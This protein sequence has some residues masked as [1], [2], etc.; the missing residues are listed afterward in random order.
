MIISYSG[1]IALKKWK[2]AKIA[3]LGADEFKQNEK[4]TFSLG[5]EFH[6]A[7]EQFSSNGEV[8][9]SDLSINQLWQSVNQSLNE[10]KPKAVLMEQLILHAKLKYKGIID[11]IS[12]V[13]DE[14]CAFQW[15]TSEKNGDLANVF[16]LTKA[17]L[18][19]Y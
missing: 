2:M 4:E 19:K 8:Q 13:R 14:L 18:L 5:K 12:L 10:L 7:I 17:D 9:E 15:K 1:V 11:N 6:S 16:E 3:E